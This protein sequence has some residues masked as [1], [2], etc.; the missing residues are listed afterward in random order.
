[1]KKTLI[2]MIA[3]AFAFS[4]GVAQA[5][6]HEGAGMKKEE[7]KKEQKAEKKGEKKAEKKK[8]EKKDGAKK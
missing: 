7:A 5:A 1:M 3:A 6:K 2:A 8:E 4:F